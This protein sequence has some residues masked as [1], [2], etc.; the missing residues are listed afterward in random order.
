MNKE[1]IIE[2]IKKLENYNY[3]DECPLLKKICKEHIDYLRKKLKEIE[4]KC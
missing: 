1:Q 3:G 2:Q 4:G